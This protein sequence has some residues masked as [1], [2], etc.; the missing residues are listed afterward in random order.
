MSAKPRKTKPKIETNPVTGIS[1]LTPPTK[2]RA[3]RTSRPPVV[4][5]PTEPP[6][7]C[8]KPGGQARIIAGTAQNLRDLAEFF[9]N[10]QKVLTMAG[11]PRA[12]TSGALRQQAEYLD[13]I[14][15]ELRDGITS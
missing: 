4:P 6:A 10:D 14:A 5:K 15:E 13:Q 11:I 8:F 2:Q 1:R 12:I 3:T 9:L 7:S